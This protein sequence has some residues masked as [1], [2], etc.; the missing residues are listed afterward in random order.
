MSN[1]VELY[2]LHFKDI[3]ITRFVMNEHIFIQH[4]NYP[5]NG[6]VKFI[7]MASQP[8]VGSDKSRGSKIIKKK[9]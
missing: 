3:L 8:S 9:K 7:I 2:E 5:A 4:F 6:V 1:F